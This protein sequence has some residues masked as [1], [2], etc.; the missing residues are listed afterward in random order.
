MSTSTLSPSPPSG[1]AAAPGS[2]PPSLSRG[3][4]DGFLGHANFRWLKLALLL[5]AA[6]T[7]A[8][9]RH[10]PVAGA[11][12]GTWLGYTLG[13]IG[14]ALILAL[15]ALG[16]RRRRYSSRLGTV[17]GWTSAHV[18]LGL[19]LVL[20]GTLHSAFE[21]GW[22]IHTLAWLLMLLVVLSGL[23]GVVAY[24]RYPALITANRAG[25]SRDQWLIDLDEAD[26]RVLSLASA[27]DRETHL[28]VLRAIEATTISNRMRDH[29]RGRAVQV[30][31]A[32]GGA[33]TLLERITAQLATGHRTGDDA[34]RVAELIDLLARR[35]SLLTRLGRDLAF[36]ARMRVWLMLHVPMTLALLAALTGHIVSVFLYW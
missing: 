1:V 10:A 16:I 22:N 12:G 14:T 34:R 31:A 36:H 3:V 27:V 11:N 25:K 9:W 6:S 19:A 35:H 26:E 28:L 24:S 33:G 29:L 17:R 4:H 23:Y 15:S 5:C 7:I 8:Y 2:T 30:R 20:V 18:W 13:G 21:F 32:H